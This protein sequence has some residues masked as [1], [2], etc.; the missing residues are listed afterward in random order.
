MSVIG[1]WIDNINS[2][3]VDNFAKEK[4]FKIIT[5]EKKTSYTRMNNRVY[6]RNFWVVYMNN[7]LL[8]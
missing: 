1:L 3:R 6:K 7:S 5:L 2:K 4:Y 8:M